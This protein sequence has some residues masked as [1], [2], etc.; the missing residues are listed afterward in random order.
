MFLAFLEDAFSGAPGSS[1]VDRHLYQLSNALSGSVLSSEPWSRMVSPGTHV[2]MAMVV[3]HARKHD[4]NSCHSPNCGGIL[5]DMPPPIAKQWFVS[6]HLLS[7]L[8]NR[9]VAH[10]AERK[11]WPTRS[12]KR[13]LMEPTLNLFQQQNIHQTVL[14]HQ[15]RGRTLWV[16]S[17]VIF[18]G[19]KDLR[20]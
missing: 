17:A 5:Q 1:W 3:F 13:Q 19:K 11:S 9:A 2:N 4:Q 7:D 12:R 15:R 14:Y 18:P 16:L 6:F 8:A 10:C 20:N